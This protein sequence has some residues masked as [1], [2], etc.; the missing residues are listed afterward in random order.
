MRR[1]APT[2]GRWPNLLHLTSD[3]RR[4]AAL[5]GLIAAGLFVW[6]HAR[7]WGVL[8]LSDDLSLIHNMSALGPAEL[9]W[10][11]S[12]RWFGPIMPGTVMWR[13]LPYSSYVLSLLVSGEVAVYWRLVNVA[14]HVACAIAVVRL[15]RSLAADRVVAIFGGA[16]FLLQPWVPEV[17]IWLVGRYDGFAT[18]FIVLSL[19][20]A[21]RTRGL[22]RMWFFGLIAAACAYASKESA[23]TLLPLVALIGVYRYWTARE[24]GLARQYLPTLLAHGALLA[25]YFV[26]RK[27]VLARATVDVYG[28]SLSLSELY[29]LIL[30]FIEHFAFPYRHAVAP[31]QVA[32]FIVIAL[33]L[34]L[35]IAIARRQSRA[36]ALMGLGLMATALAALAVAFAPFGGERDGARMYYLATVGLSVACAAAVAMPAVWVRGSACVLLIALAF[37]QRESVDRWAATSEQMSALK[38]AIVNVRASHTDDEFAFVVVPAR[39][40]AVPFAL[41]AQSA[42]SRSTP[43]RQLSRLFTPTAQEIGDWHSVMRDG[44]LPTFF[45]DDRVPARPTH[46]YCVEQGR[47]MPLGVWGGATRQEWEATWRQALGKSCPTLL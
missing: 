29:P 3:D 32:A 30:R 10:H 40:D 22:D 39:I 34:L 33:L 15:L 16:M 13:P 8:A 5:L 44:T 21:A 28:S 43:S 20:A 18:L 27:L 4:V 46:F 19:T 42:L 45:P 14:V 38:Q 6:T 24:P 41:N 35:A 26:I 23:V 11:M 2:V 37:F 12:E 7:A 25:L 47:L 9:F 17:S 31:S 1:D 36:L